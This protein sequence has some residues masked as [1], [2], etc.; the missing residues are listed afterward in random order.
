MGFFVFT[1]MFVGP[2]LFASSFNPLAKGDQAAAASHVLAPNVFAN[3]ALT[4]QSAVVYDTTKDTILFEKNKDVVLPLA[5][6]TK[7]LSA[8]VLKDALTNTQSIH[9]SEHA[10]GTD[11]DSGL[12]A[13]EQWN[14]NDLI[15]FSLT[16]SSNDGIEALKDAAEARTG[17]SM[18]TRMNRYA[19]D[20]GWTSMQFE[21]PTGLDVLGTDGAPLH[22]GA[23]G[24]AYD[25]ARMFAHV[26]VR[27]PNLYD[28]TA[29]TGTVYTSLSGIAHTADN[30]NIARGDIPGLVAS[31]TGF[32]DLAGG[33]L[34]VAFEPEPGRRIIVV[35]LGSTM[36]GRFTDVEQLVQRTLEY[37]WFE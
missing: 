35:V 12:L 27:Y 23:V 16:T 19:A 5:S 37:L 30:T 34:V 11:G 29:H 13:Q 3:V 33:N 26:L 10:L 18:V 1:L 25:V 32:T 31:K 8:L 2:A 9:V 15:E 14:V 28:A 6:V 21:N 22:P 20:A 24:S 17:E 4:A 36:E 7:T